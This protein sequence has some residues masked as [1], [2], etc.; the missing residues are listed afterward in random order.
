MS[1]ETSV[2]SRSV[3]I[4]SNLLILLAVGTASRDYITK[5]KAT[6]SFLPEDYDLL[7]RV[8]DQA[9]DVLLLPNTLTETSNLAW[10]SGSFAEP[11]RSKVIHVLRSL[12]DTLREDTV[13]CRTAAARA[14]FIRLG[15][16]DAAILELSRKEIVILTTDLDLCVAAQAAGKP[17]INFNHLREHYLGM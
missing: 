7:I 1:T 5:H 8:L 6:K 3:L 16:T 2:V 9:S 14:E 12:I 10:T 17:V 15:L 4:D 13:P 11:G